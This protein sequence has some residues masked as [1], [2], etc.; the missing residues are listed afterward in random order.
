[1]TDQRS[2][3]PAARIVLDVDYRDGAFELVLANIGD[4][5]AHDIRVD[6][7]RKLIGADDTV[8]SALPVFQQLRTLRP[9]K[10]I[11]VFLDAAPGLFRRRKINT[12][13]ATVVWSG[14]TRSKQKAR[15]RHDL[16]AY[17]G[18]PEIVVRHER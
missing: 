10:E 17:R 2:E 16:D 14:G 3:R 18:M 12:F 4:D 8:V 6:F 11:R 15:Y 7:S 5:V 9:G 1:M 13:T